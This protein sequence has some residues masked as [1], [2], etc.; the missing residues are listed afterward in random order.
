MRLGSL[1]SILSHTATLLLGV[2]IALL[3]ISTVQLNSVAT[4]GGSLHNALVPQTEKRVQE[5]QQQ[6][7]DELKAQ[8][9]K[10]QQNSNNIIST[11]GTI[12][13][14]QKENSATGF[15]F[16]NKKIREY[17]GKLLTNADLI[18]H[19]KIELT[20]NRC[21][22]WG[23][24]TTIF[25][26]TDAISRVASLPNWC[27]V[28]VADLKTPQNFMS[29][30]KTLQG[31]HQYQASMERVTYLSVEEQRKWETDAS[32]PVSD[33]LYSIPWNH[34]CRKNIGYLFVSSSH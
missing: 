25:N 1:R 13:S 34:F 27:L 31:G 15:L 21:K 3:I 17:H 14:N 11:G 24:V 12:Y 28:I 26:P 7:N 18:R 8:I 19:A 4:S 9:S 22:Q 16:E 6:Q 29:M 10:L 30:F 33:Y 23:V 5:E 2:F 20:T 32:G